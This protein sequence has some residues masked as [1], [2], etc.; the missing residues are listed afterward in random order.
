M[1]PTIMSRRQTPLTTPHSITSPVVNELEDSEAA[2]V[3]LAFLSVGRPE[4]PEEMATVESSDPVHQFDSYCRT[5]PIAKTP[6]TMVVYLKRPSSVSSL[7][8]SIFIS[9]IDISAIRTAIRAIWICKTNQ[10]GLAAKISFF[11]FPPQTQ[12]LISRHRC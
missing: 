7:H 6:S 11:P 2:A 10:L 1:C 5:E 8:S 4:S 3:V 9:S 12:C